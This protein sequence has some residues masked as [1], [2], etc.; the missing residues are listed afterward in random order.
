MLPENERNR[1][2]KSTSLQ[3]RTKHMEQNGVIK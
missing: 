1:L 3:S 2:M